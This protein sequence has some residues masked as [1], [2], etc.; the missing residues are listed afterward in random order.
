M[1]YIN[2]INDTFQLQIN[3]KITFLMNY[4]FDIQTVILYK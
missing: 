3:I 1:S 2:I 4:I